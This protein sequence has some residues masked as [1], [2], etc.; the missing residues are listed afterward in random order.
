MAELSQLR[1]RDGAMQRWLFQ[2]TDPS[3][4]VESWLD[5][6]WADHLRA[7]ERASVAYQK[8]EQKI[9]ELTRSGSTIPVRHFVPPEPQP[10]SEDMVRAFGQGA[11]D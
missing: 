8:I 10:L 1:R 2:D 9:R 3:R 11:R 7:H 5:A 4:F 6:T